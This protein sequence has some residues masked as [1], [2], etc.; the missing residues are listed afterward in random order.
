M[1]GHKQHGDLKYICNSYEESD[2]KECE[3]NAVSSERLF[4]FACRLVTHGLG[5]GAG[6]AAARSQRRRLPG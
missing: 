2:G 3:H 4:E 1:Y 6:E 5:V